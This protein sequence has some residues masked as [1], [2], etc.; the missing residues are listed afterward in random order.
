M[1]FLITLQSAMVSINGGC[2]AEEMSFSQ[3][4]RFTFPA[5]PHF[6]TLQDAH[7]TASTQEQALSVQDQQSQRFLETC[8]EGFQKSSVT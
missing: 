6:W 1:K 8:S 5:Y 4:A 2:T 3:Q 7:K